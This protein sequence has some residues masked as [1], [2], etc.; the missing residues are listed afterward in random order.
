MNIGIIIHSQT[1]NT[2]SVAIKLKDKLIKAG[3]IVSIEKV[4]ATN[5]REQNPRKI[6][7]KTSPEVIGYDAIIF[8]APVRGF[9]LSPVLTAYLKRI[10]TLQGKKVVCFVTEFFPYPWMGGTRAIKQMN[11]ICESK[12]GEVIGAGIVNWSS[13]HRLEQIDNILG[14]QSSLF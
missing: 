4:I 10:E 3:H 7:L 6:N 12:A 1:G 5:D 14:K 2:Y 13:K 8:G 11:N 9:S